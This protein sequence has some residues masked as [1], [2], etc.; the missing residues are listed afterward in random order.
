MSL[1]WVPETPWTRNSLFKVYPPL[2]L[3]KL[4]LVGRECLGESP[5]LLAYA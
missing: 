3:S 1:G 5:L 2:V 4:A